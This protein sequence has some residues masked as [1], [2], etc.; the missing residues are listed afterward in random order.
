MNHDEWIQSTKLASGNGISDH[1]K[2]AL[3]TNSELV[4]ESM[5][6]R[7]E[8]RIAINELLMVWYELK[9]VSSYIHT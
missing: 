1:L 7:N 6:L 2:A 3:E 5:K 9:F 4:S 8:A